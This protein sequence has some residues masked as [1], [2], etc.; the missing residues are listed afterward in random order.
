MNELNASRKEFLLLSM[1]EYPNEE[2]NLSSY[3]DWAVSFL[4]QP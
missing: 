2:K 3:T 1:N 4:K